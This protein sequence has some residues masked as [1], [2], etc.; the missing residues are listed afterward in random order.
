MCIVI[1]V[2]M[3]MI[4]MQKKILIQRRDVEVYINNG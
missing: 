3:Q 2:V 4:L 1:E